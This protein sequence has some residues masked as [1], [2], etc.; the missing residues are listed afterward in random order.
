M[1]LFK[2]KI[3]IIGG[4]VRG[5]IY[6]DPNARLSCGEGFHELDSR[7]CDAIAEELKVMATRMRMIEAALK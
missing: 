4:T 3:E 7:T 6:S 5:Q 1:A 2:S